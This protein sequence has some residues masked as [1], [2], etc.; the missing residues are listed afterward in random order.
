MAEELLAMAD[1]EKYY[2][3]IHIMAMLVLGFGFLMVFVRKYGRST[4]TAT[5]LLVSVSIPLYYLLDSLGILGGVDSDIDRLI[6]A[7]FAAAGLLICAGAVLG[8]LKMYHCLL[9]TSDA[10]DE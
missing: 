9:Y 5:Y 3:A 4:L 10:A 1:V 8:R 2:R 7:E 6:L